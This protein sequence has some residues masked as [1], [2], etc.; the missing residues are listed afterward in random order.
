MINILFRVGFRAAA[1]S[2]RGKGP[3]SMLGRQADPSVKG[4]WSV[5]FCF[6]RGIEA[7]PL[8]RRAA[9]AGACP[10]RG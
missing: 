8:G 2:A 4:S 10:N 5:C 3:G 1:N 9:P 6:L 7:R